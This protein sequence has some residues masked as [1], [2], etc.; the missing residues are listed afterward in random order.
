MRRVLHLGSA[1]GLFLLSVGLAEAQEAK[2]PFVGCP[3]AGMMG[4]GPAPIAAT[5]IP[6]VPAKDAARLAYYASAALGILAP[7]GW[8][9]FGIYGSSGWT[10]LVT[11]D[12]L[13]DSTYAEVG[14]YGIKVLRGQADT[15]G[16][17]IVAHV[18]AGH[19]PVA[20]SFV[21]HVIDMEFEPK[22]GFRTKPFPKDKLIRR[23]DT[24]IEFT[25]PGN[26]DGL[27]TLFGLEKTKDP[28]RGVA[29]L[30]PD[31]NMDLL[32]AHIRLPPDLQNLVGTI[33]AGVESN[34]AA[35]GKEEAEATP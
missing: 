9:C 14:R 10:L 22:E 17:S 13:P 2:V 11:P 1:V 23:S 29:I 32:K 31:E 24:V 28:I 26:T 18:A 33:I 25:T 20:K 5:I 7:R 30:M 12:P 27:G 34:R 35:P 19:F 21:Q 15:S 4:D 3:S 8:S 16:R 6:A